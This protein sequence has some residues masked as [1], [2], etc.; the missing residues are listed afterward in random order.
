MLMYALK[1]CQC[2]AGIDLCVSLRV[3]VEHLLYMVRIDG[4]C[5]VG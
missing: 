2:V 4:P 5:F 1:F 3:F